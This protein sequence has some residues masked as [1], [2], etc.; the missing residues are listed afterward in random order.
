MHATE[1]SYQDETAQDLTRKHLDVK[2]VLIQ[3]M[4][5]YSEITSDLLL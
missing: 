1:G 2:D 3:G 5:R 4:Y